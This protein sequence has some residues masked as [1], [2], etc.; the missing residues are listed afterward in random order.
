[1]PD[2]FLTQRFARL[3]A[4][5]KAP[6]T[7]G[8]SAARAPITLIL[9]VAAFVTLFTNYRFF[10][11]FLAIYPLT[12]MNLVFVVST[13]LVLIALTALLLGLVCIGPLL[14]PLLIA[15]LMVSAN[16][17]YFMDTYHVIID[18]VMLDNLLQTDSAEAL[19]L[20]S[21]W[22]A[23]YCVILGLL[24]SLFIA[25]VPIARRPTRRYPLVQAALRRVGFVASCLAA[26]AALLLS[27]GS[28]YASFF[29]EHKDVRFYANPSYTFYSAATL[30]SGLF[31]RATR[32]FEHIG[33]DAVRT[34]RSERRRLVVMIVGE[35]LRSDHLALNGYI[36]D[37]TPLLAARG[38]SSFTDLWSC[39]TSTAVSVPC[40]FS[41]LGHDDYSQ[42]EA[43]AT[44]NALDVVQRTG[45]RVAW[46]DN[47]SD[48]KGVAPRL[49]NFDFKDP[50][51]NPRCDIECRD[52][53]MT[54]GLA[55]YVQ[56]RPDGDLLIVMH[57]MGN[58][59][60][61]YYKRYPSEFERFTPT[62]RTNQLES[63]SREEII[64]AYDN[65]VLYTDYFL[66]STI[67]WLATVE[68]EFDTAMVYIGD[69]GE[70]LGE[71]NL[72]LH[73]LPYAFAPDIQKRVPLITWFG[74]NW[75]QHD[76][77]VER[78]NSRRHTQAT[79]DSVSHTLLGLFDVST[80][81]YDP[82]A[83]LFGKP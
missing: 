69:H 82:E 27:Q 35:T 80:T 34:T 10:S 32:P 73:G 47:N 56:Q 9:W 7:L 71:G 45:V 17:A 24:P 78:I 37:T 18:D 48:S 44:D 79:H 19:D 50:E 16:T 81:L 54:A 83:D 46:F 76:E 6:L 1:M 38:V 20:L 63:C 43:L 8:V 61:A 67:D 51:V 49:P 15:A 55:N 30:V 26:I 40:M 68:D 39:G 64:N 53:G 62:C 3:S 14:K 60:P 59:G 31:E 11:E 12:A 42:A 77:L 25:R 29:R 2:A 75:P 28:S 65:A 5:I 52:I 4:S 13:T 36:R 70:S 33:L 66:A 72:Y 58:H 57:A 21:F 74:A 41:F 23:V 22:Q